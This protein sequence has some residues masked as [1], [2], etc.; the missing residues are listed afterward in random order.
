M[1]YLKN[2]APNLINDSLNIPYSENIL[3]RLNKCDLQKVF[4]RTFDI[5]FD[6]IEFITNQMIYNLFL[7]FVK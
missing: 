4:K 2:A 5:A 1:N 6:Q 7:F 3:V